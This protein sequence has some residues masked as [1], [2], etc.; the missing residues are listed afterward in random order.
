[1]ETSQSAGKGH[2]NQNGAAALSPGDADRGIATAQD[3][4]NAPGQQQSNGLAPNES[5]DGFVEILRQMYPSVDL[6]YLQNRLGDKPVLEDVQRIAEELAASSHAPRDDSDSATV[7]TDGARDLDED[8]SQPLKRNKGGL[9]KKLGR[10]FNGLRGS[11]FGGATLGSSGPTQSTVELRKPAPNVSDA[12][13]HN[14]L[15]AMLQNAVK[16]A[17]HVNAQGVH[18]HET[19]L[20][21][22]PDGLDRGE[23]CEL[24]PG[25]SL[26]PFAGPTGTF[27]THN[28]IRVFSSRGVLES[29]EF[30]QQNQTTVESFSL[31]IERM[32]SIYGLPLA[33]VAIFYQPSGQTIAFNSNRAL[34]FNVRFYH[35]LHFQSNQRFSADCYSY[36]FVTMAHE[37]AHNLASGHN[38]EHGFYTES[39]VTLYLPKLLAVIGKD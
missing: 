38:K 4:N 3:P 7:E 16:S 19:T 2:E 12:Q 36:W 24:L 8:S 11:N 18:S 14:H 9:R 13:S 21:S 23:T 27:K 26:Q 22:I 5:K 29:E 1:M 20:T 15:E 35:T 25:H 30:L 37:L 33:T 31:V 39:Y 28:G 6:S 10:A 32:C 34:H 17:S